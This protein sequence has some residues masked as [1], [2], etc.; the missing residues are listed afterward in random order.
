LLNYQKKDFDNYDGTVWTRTCTGEIKS[1][2]E[3]KVSGEIPRWINGSLLQ[4]GPGAYNIG[5]VM[6]NHVFDGMAVLHRFNIQNGKVTYQHRFI[7]SKAYDSV[8]EENRITYSEF[9]TNSDPL[10]ST[11]QR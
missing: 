5:D 3:G 8:V 11:F 10:G 1:P 4:N 7:K 6:F 9:A 2:I